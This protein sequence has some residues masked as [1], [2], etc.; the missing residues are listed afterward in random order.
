MWKCPSLLGAENDPKIVK[1]H[2]CGTACPRREN[3]SK[4]LAHFPKDCIVFV[5][6]SMHFAIRKSGKHHSLC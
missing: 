2:L 6:E 3:R 1:S 5:A 4:N